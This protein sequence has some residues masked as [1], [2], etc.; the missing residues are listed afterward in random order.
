MERREK[1][2]TMVNPLDFDALKRREVEALE[3]LERARTEQ[4]RLAALGAH[5]GWL[6]ARLNTVRP[7][8]VLNL[9]LYR[10][11]TVMSAGAAYMLFFSVTAAVVAS[12]SV[13]GLIIG[14]NRELQ[15]LIV[16]AVDGALPGVIDTG[17]GGLAR[18]DQLFSTQGFN[19]TLVVSLIVLVVTSLSWIQG[20][21]SG[22][23]TIFAKPLMDENILVVKL[24]DLAVMVLV[25]VMLLIA[26]VIGLASSLFVEG[27]LDFLEWDAGGLQWTL[28]RVLSILVPFVLDVLIAVLLFRVA[29]R[30]VMPR[31]ALWRAT[32]LA[33]I[34]SSALRL[35]S[36][37]LV[38]AGGS[39][40]ILAPFTA[41]LGLFFYFFILSIVYLFSAAWAAVVTAELKRKRVAAAAR[42]GSSEGGSTARS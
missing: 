30:I 40:P 32:L 17:D 18:P 19:S 2:P 9:F 25:G 11:G 14:G 33:G 5:I 1:T 34:G 36:T 13:A 15:E 8:R 38:F 20:L 27:V 42:R 6:Q 10:Y 41:V 12:F 7:M 28:T 23:R 22:I 35:L 21:R 39:N 16:V 3:A 24:R 37:Q 26:G 31:A 29:S 4:G